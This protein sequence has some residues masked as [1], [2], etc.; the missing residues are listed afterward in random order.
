MAGI[1]GNSDQEDVMNFNF[2]RTASAIAA[3]LCVALPGVAVRAVAAEAL[4]VASVHYTAAD[5]TSPTAIAGL[6]DRLDRAAHLVCGSVDVRDLARYQE[7]HGCVVQ[8][9]S[10]GVRQ[11]RNTELRAYHQLRTGAPVEVADSSAIRLSEAL[12]RD[13][14]NR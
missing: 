12:P 5:L 4:P 13:G 11:I 10:A 2:S 3:L 14:R 9:L 8:A 7:W 6:Y 1:N